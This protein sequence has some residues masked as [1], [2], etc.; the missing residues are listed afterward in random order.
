V[1]L[2]GKERPNVQFDPQACW[3][4]GLCANTCPAEAIVIEPLD[5]GE[6]A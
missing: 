1:E 3:G 4:C 2:D 5:E 6:V